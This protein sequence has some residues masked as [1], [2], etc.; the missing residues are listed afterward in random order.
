MA[1]GRTRGVAEIGAREALRARTALNP[2]ATLGL[3][4]AAARA[5]IVAS[6][7]RHHH[8]ADTPTG[9]NVVAHSQGARRPRS[10]DEL[11]DASTSASLVLK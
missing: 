3:A 2:T 1:A 9:R 4:P 7:L 6:E 8:E 11:L 5:G 10:P